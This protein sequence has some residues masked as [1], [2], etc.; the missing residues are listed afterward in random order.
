MLAGSRTRTGKPKIERGHQPKSMALRS[1]SIVEAKSNLAGLPR[2]DQDEPSSPVNAGLKLTHLSVGLECASM[3]PSLVIEK[4]VRGGRGS[5][6][7]QTS[8][9]DRVFQQPRPS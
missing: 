5:L 9:R 2:R 3:L 6:A 1:L 4:S 7:N 8:R